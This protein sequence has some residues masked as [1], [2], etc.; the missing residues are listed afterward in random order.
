MWHSVTVTE[1]ADSKRSK[2]DVRGAACLSLCGVLTAKVTLD[3]L[4][5]VSSKELVGV[6]VSGWSGVSGRSEEVVVEGCDP[7]P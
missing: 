5:E 2:R 1:D 7:L 3:G 4:L 6:V